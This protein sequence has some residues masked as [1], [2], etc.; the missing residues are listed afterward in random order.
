[1]V[2]D[3]FNTC[4]SRWPGQGA[5]AQGGNRA[6]PGRAGRDPAR[7]A[8]NATVVLQGASFLNDGDR[9][10]VSHRPA[11]ARAAAALRTRP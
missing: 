5:A 3:G 8:P 7:L 2:R 1:V 6:P 9:V 4:S 10:R 11:P